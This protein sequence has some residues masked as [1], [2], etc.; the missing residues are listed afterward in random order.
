MVAPRPSSLGVIGPRSP[1]P[2]TLRQTLEVTRLAVLW[3]AAF[4]LLACEA[5]L[6]GYLFVTTYGS[7]DLRDAVVL[8]A[9]AP[10]VMLVVSALLVFRPL[11]WCTRAHQSSPP[12]GPFISSLVASAFFGL[13]GLWLAIAEG[14]H[15]A[16]FLV[17]WPLVAQVVS[18][19]LAYLSIRKWARH[20]AL[21]ALP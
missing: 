4:S 9:I 20:Q 17:F 21:H 2:S 12:F 16:G 18:F 3:S 15:T 11:Y 6:A 19:S 8:F 13:G 1:A 5:A 14:P 7:F 10:G